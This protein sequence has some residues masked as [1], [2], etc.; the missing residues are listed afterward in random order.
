MSSLL[1]GVVVFVALLKAI[2]NHHPQEGYSGE[3][4]GL[5]VGHTA[6]SRDYQHVRAPT[7]TPRRAFRTSQE[8]SPI[9]LD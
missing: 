7:E 5:P 9:D 8:V 6:R 4:L 2:D 3:Q 1:G